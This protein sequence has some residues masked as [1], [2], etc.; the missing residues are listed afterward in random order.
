MNQD[1]TQYCFVCGDP[2]NW[3]KLDAYQIDCKVA[4]SHSFV[5][6]C[7]HT[8]EKNLMYKQT[9]SKKEKKKINNEF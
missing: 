7:S 1:R 3:M 8:C 2:I 4:D 9:T 6:I 5:Y